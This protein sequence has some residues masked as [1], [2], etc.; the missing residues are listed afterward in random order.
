MHTRDITHH[1]TVD[2]YIQDYSQTIKMKGGLRYFADDV[3]CHCVHHVGYFN[4]ITVLYH[5]RT[6]LSCACMQAM[7][8]QSLSTWRMC[9]LHVHVDV[10][11]HNNCDTAISK[12]GA[13]G[14]KRGWSNL[15]GGWGGGGGEGSAT[16]C[17][18]GV[19]PDTSSYREMLTQRQV[20][21]GGLWSI[22]GKSRRFCHGWMHMN[23]ASLRKNNRLLVLHNTLLIV[24]NSQDAWVIERG[25]CTMCCVVL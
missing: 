18:F 17:M 7:H 22:E 14:Y 25:V 9:V 3:I 8:P 12:H 16:L 20:K 15:E 2:R 23:T 5:T 24:R 21:L 4:T 10:C 11:V 1:N 6:V 19:N 13:F